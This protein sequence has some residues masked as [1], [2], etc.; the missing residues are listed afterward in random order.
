MGKILDSGFDAEIARALLDVM[1]EA[2]YSPLEAI[3]GLILAVHLLAEKSGAPEQARRE[4]GDLLDA[5]P[6]GV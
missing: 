2:G 1:E 6:E 3:P 5:D 4:A